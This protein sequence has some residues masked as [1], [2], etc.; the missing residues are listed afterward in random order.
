MANQLLLGRALDANGYIAPG[1][2]ATVYA[3]G[4]STLITVYS[5]VDGATPAANPIVA[6]G[7][8]FWP[9]RYVTEDAKAVVTTSADVAL[10]TLDPAPTSRGTGAAASAVSFSPTIDLPQTNVQAAIEAAAALAVSGFAEFGLGITGN[11][12]LLANLDA[13]GTGAGL[14]R[15]D[16][17]TT[18]TY[19][20]GVAAGDTGLV[21]HWRQAGATAMMELHHATSNRVFHRRM[22]ASVWG[23]WREVLTVN[24][25]AAQG[26]IIYRGASAWTRLA[27]GTA[28]QTL[29]MNSGATDPEWGGSRTLMAAQAT[30]SGSSVTFTIPAG[31]QR[32]SVLLKSVSLTVAG[33]LVIRIGPSGGVE[34]TAYQSNST[35]AQGGGGNGGGDSTVGA[36][37]Y[38]DN[39]AFNISGLFIFELMDVSTNT[40]V[41]NGN[42]YA[43]N[44]ITGVSGGMKAIAGTLERI[45]L[46]ATAGAFDNGSVAVAYEF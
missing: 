30:T 43:G 9:Q 27:K 4:T 10:Y 33:S 7:D 5:D 34:T 6:D 12:T 35:G 15:F 18:G 36:G 2:K 29:R 26:D 23:T 19:P 45:A 3:D 17:T 42:N 25:G 20:T 40:W 22:D 28:N 44:N 11:A 8:G 13:T 16:G 41:W 32:I 37:V 39:A 46:V 1:A 21:E 31:V 14:Y 24:Q 38:N